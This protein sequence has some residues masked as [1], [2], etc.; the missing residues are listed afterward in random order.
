MLLMPLP[1]TFPIMEKALPPPPA[2]DVP[3]PPGAEPWFPPSAA[4]PAPPEVWELLQPA[5]ADP[6]L[7]GTVTPPEPD[8]EPSGF[9]V[10]LPD[11]GEKLL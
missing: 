1:M 7:A 4:V 5:P 8:G 10:L 3:K 11:S 9:P 6:P 2:D